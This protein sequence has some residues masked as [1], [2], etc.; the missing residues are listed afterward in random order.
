MAL[1]ATASLGIGS[2]GVL[3]FKTIDAFKEND[4]KNQVNPI[5]KKIEKN[6]EQQTELAK[7]ITNITSL[8]TNAKNLSDL[9]T[10]QKR[11][12]T[13]EG[14][15]IKATA[16]S[17]LAVQDIKVNVSQLAQNDVNQVGLKFA[18]RDSVFT[19]KNTTLNFHHQ[20]TDYNI[21]IRAGMTLAE[22]GQA[23]T[24][25]TDGKVL[26][27]IMKTGGDNPYQLMIQSK[28]SGADQ[29]IYFGSTLVGAALPGGKIDT[30][31][32]GTFKINIAGEQL[33]IDVKDIQNSNFGNTAEQNA[34]ALL[35]AVNKKLEDP[36][37]SK[38]KGLVDSGQVTITLN[39]NGTGLMLN[40]SKGGDIS[41]ETNNVQFQAAEGTT[42]T[43]TDLGFSTKATQSSSQAVGKKGVSNAANLSG[44]FSINGTSFD[45]SN[46]NS[47]TG[48]SNAEKIAALINNQTSST[49]VSAKVENGKLVLNHNTGEDITLSSN[50][51]KVLDS[52]GL[53]AGVYT[54]SKNFLKDMDIT[55]IQQAQNAKLTYNGFN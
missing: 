24:D 32:G 7:L 11:S 22:V 44:T 51:D 31:N 16:G 19:T 14:T 40:D 45:L 54:T 10:Y 27:I 41:V 33:S 30:T 55:N 17:G 52:M 50:D 2:N 12:T 38:L 25:T 42:S 8:N 37:N 9:S 48:N 49:N 46:I 47:Q 29:K 28:D 26:G 53:N 36:A 43:S 6:V 39:K 20:G 34:K 13:V 3:N 23:I 5:T 21:N 4:V 15:G 35:D 1:G 18:S